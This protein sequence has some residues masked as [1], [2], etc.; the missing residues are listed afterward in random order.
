MFLLGFYLFLPLTAGNDRGIVGFVGEKRPLKIDTKK[1]AIVIL[2][3]AFF[4][5]KTF[6]AASFVTKGERLF[7]RP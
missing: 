7:L 5:P 1:A 3:A 6:A 4:M 2:L